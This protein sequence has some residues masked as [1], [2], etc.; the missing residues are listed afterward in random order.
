[1][2]VPEL[3]SA[4]NSFLTPILYESYEGLAYPLFFS[5]ILCIFSFVCAVVL[6]ILDKK[7]ELN[8]LSIYLLYVEG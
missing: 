1:M 5:V 2:T 6:C 7:D 3:A 8:K 4:A